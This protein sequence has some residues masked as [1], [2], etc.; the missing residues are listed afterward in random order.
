MGGDK[1]P[2][3]IRRRGESL[4]YTAKGNTEIRLLAQAEGVEVMRQIVAQG[5]M[6]YL[7][8]AEEWQ[9]F[10]FIYLLSG[11]LSYLG[12]EPPVTLEPG[13]YIVRRLVP[14]RSWFRAE[15]NTELLYVSSRPAFEVMR[16]EIEEFRK[17][18]QQVE[19]DEY[20]HG[21]SRR[22]EGL[23][24]AVGER[25]G[26][27]P[28]RLADLTHAAL[29]H[30]VGKARVPKEIL[31]KPDKLTPE[32]WEIMKMHTIWGREMLERRPSLARAALIVEQTHERFDGT[33]YPH[34]LSGEEIMLEARII[35]V[36]DAYDAMTTDRPYRRALP[37]DQAIAELRAGAGTQFDPQVVDAFLS[38]LA[39]YERSKG[40]TW[41]D[42]DIARGQQRTAFLR[43]AR[44]I[45]RG[46]KV[47]VILRQVL[48]GI[49]SYT[50]FRRAALA[51]Y[52]RPV[53][54][55]EVD[56]AQL[57]HLETVGLTPE[58]EARLRAH[59]L[60]PAQRKQ[61]LQEEF[62]IGR[63]FY[64]PHD[65]WPWQELP[66]AARAP[67]P[68][69]EGASWHPDDI[70]LVPLW[71]EEERLVG[72]ISL[73]DPVDGRVPTAEALE[74]VEMFA[75]LAAL[76][77]VEAKRRADLERAV[78]ELKELSLRDPLTGVYNRRFL[79]DTLTRE[80]ARASRE[81]K[82]LGLI[83]LDL[84]NFHEVNKRFGHLRGDRVLREVAEVIVGSVR[85]SDT[86]I[87]Y[88]SDEFVVVVPGAT[89]EQ[90]RLT[91]ARIRRRI[92][93]H[94]FGLPINLSAHTG[95]ACWTPDQD[96]KIEDLL[97]EADRWL[98]GRRRR[99]QW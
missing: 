3:F 19:D 1:R 81:G 59:P 77:V 82:P 69:R 55:A 75:S 23:A 15:E 36:V 88:G 56:Q 4:S 99:G 18:A 20:T 62:R 64:I 98:Y 97:A 58:E 41:F 22:L 25:L 37:R 85:A 96:T 16:E 42:D 30:D 74:P 39:E 27:P 78:R 26:L 6:F 45:L 91:A 84:K 87:R 60:S 9:G 67:T 46:G 44:S 80:M 71:V 90:A 17:I 13:D 49:T 11:R 73:D 79:K 93:E 7:D 8:S 68:P 14:E 5:A 38:V 57:V 53:S 95:A 24:V 54:L 35:A 94:D 63:S 66:G 86:V 40:G 92:K 34:G 28:D 29:F 43:I 61:A 76:A 21:H 52:D 10:E 50:P 32:E 47:A 33:G 48:E 83:M 2:N 89:L 12:S 70:L 72:L 65:R 51:L 31:Q